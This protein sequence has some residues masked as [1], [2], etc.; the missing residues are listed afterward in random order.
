LNLFLINFPD[1]PNPDQFISA[2][3]P[4]SLAADNAGLNAL[5]GV[6]PAYVNGFVPSIFELNG[7]NYV[8][9]EVA[10]TNAGVTTTALAANPT[11][12]IINNSGS[13][14]VLE[15]SSDNQ[16]ENI[17]SADNR[18]GVNFKNGSFGNHIVDSTLTGN[19][20]HD[21]VSSSDQNNFIDNSSFNFSNGFVSGDGVLEVFFKFKVFV[22]NQSNQPL[23]PV[24]VVVKNALGNIVTTLQTQINGESAFTNL[25]GTQILSKSNYNSNL[26]GGL[27]PFLF[28]SSFNGLSLNSNQ[29]IYTR[30]EI[31]NL[32][33]LPVVSGGGSGGGNGGVGAG[34]PYGRE[35]TQGGEVFER[36]NKIEEKTD[37][38]KKEI[39]FDYFNDIANSWA[40]KNI[41][42]LAKKGI[43]NGY[44][45]GSFRPN[46]DTTRA[47]FAAFIMRTFYNE[48]VQGLGFLKQA[49]FPDVSVDSWYNSILQ[50]GKNE[51]VVDGYGDELFRPDQTI[52]GAEA[53]KL[54]LHSK[55]LQ[56]EVEKTD[57]NSLDKD[58]LGQM[59]INAWYS[60]YIIWT[61]K[62]TDGEFDDLI[63]NYADPISR[64]LAAK[65]IDGIKK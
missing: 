49:A 55:K 40:R 57:L 17:T 20:D 2:Y 7:V 8:Y 27:S 37:D 41:N 5:C 39:D 64:A 62:N 34:G 12:Q 4:N 47:E 50:V 11:I 36:G 15:N 63:R 23:N 14:L 28:E 18:I 48:K 33:M 56:N 43:A 1:P 22:T 31:V 65:I 19:L 10:A 54:I 25:I 53:L 30:N 59:D 61:K 60:K 26:A 52:T 29:I 24:D 32:Q 16:F 44:P 6:P 51:N 35:A 9:N 58:E 21:L 42:S 38:K 3:I 45:D 46:I 13:G